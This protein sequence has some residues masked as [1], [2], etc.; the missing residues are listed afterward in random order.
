[1]KKGKSFFIVFV[2]LHICQ[3]AMTQ[4][5]KDYKKYRDIIKEHLYKDF[6]G[7]YR[8]PGG[9]LQYPF[10][11]PGGD[12]YGDVLWDWDSWLSNVALRQ[13]LK[14]KNSSE[15]LFEAEQYEQGCVLNYLSFSGIDGWVPITIPKDADMSK[16]KPADIYKENM[17]KPCLAQHAAFIVQQND[18][19]A[20]WLRN[21]FFRLQYFVN[22]YIN[23]YRHRTTGLYFWQNDVMIGVDN[24]PCTFFRPDRSSGSIF[25]NCMMYK[26]LRAMEYLAQCLDYNEIANEYAQNADDLKEAIQKY[27]WDERD[28]FFYS[29]DLNLRPVSSEKEQFHGGAPRNWDCLIQRIGVWSGFLAMWAD[30]ATPE[31][32]ER[33][34]K[35]HFCNK[36]TFNASYGIRT[37]SKM[38]KMYNLKA[39]GNPSS[40]LGPIWGISN[41]M[42]WRGLVKYGYSK[43]AKEL[44]TK[45]IFLFGQDYETTGVLHEYYQ[46]SNGL[47]ILNPGFQDWNM[48]VINMIAWMEGKTVISEF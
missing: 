6:K 16:S 48:L 12:Q 41:Y 36:Q 18:D 2:L 43:E 22:G 23:R 47:P 28:G 37:L 3:F 17:H 33:M 45:T 35:E 5:S 25:L 15:D 40:W 10:L 29:V 13:I 20:E 34:V 32:A 24:D 19:D 9:T 26:E 46:P 4:D 42:V 14:D 7:M 27:C 31:Q 38:E 30:I 44:A 39:S 11:V 1:M 21:E 8:S